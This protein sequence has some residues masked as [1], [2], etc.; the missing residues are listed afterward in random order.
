MRISQQRDIIEE[1]GVDLDAL[2]RMI[3]AERA[4]DQVRFK[5][6]D[7]ITLEDADIVLPYFEGEVRRRFQVCARQI[8]GIDR[9]ITAE[10]EMMEFL[11]G[12]GESDGDVG[13]GN[14]AK[15]DQHFAKLRDKVE[16]RKHQKTLFEQ[17]PNNP[18]R[19]RDKFER[20]C[21][22][23]DTYTSSVERLRARVA[24]CRDMLITIDQEGKI[25]QEAR[26]S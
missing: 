8:E 4:K 14:I 12:L 18:L 1:E 11:A 21:K 26:L 5:P 17:H 9:S 15:V 3:G 16:D 13:P 7:Q 2:A 6:L 10:E 19:L 23:D 22:D 25:W 20:T 24:Y